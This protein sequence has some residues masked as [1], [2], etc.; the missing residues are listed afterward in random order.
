LNTN[1]VKGETTISF[2]PASE[3]E[4]DEIMDCLRELSGRT[5]EVSTP[6][7]FAISRVLQ[8]FTVTAESVSITFCPGVVE[9]LGQIQDGPA[10]LVA[11]ARITQA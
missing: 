8:H 9:L 6:T 11:A 7:G 10:L 5:I 1:Q 4:A 2:A 3:D